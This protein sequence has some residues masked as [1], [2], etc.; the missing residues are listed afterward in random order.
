MSPHFALPAVNK[1]FKER[2]RT[3][4]L[5]LTVHRSF[6]GGPVAVATATVW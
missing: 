3:V 6:L 5:D 1:V 4:S 2:S